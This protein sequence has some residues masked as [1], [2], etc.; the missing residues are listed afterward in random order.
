MN[1]IGK[2]RSCTETQQSIKSCRRT[3]W[4]R[5]VLWQTS[6]S[7][8]IYLFEVGFSQVLVATCA[9]L[10]RYQISECCI[11]INGLFPNIWTA[12]LLK[13]YLSPHRAALAQLPPDLVGDDHSLLFHCVIHSTTSTLQFIIYSRDSCY[14]L[15]CPF[16]R[17]AGMSNFMQH[18]ASLHPTALHW[19]Y[20]FISLD[21]ARPSPGSDDRRILTSSI[22]RQQRSGHDSMTISIYGSTLPN[23]K[24]HLS[25]CAGP[26]NKVWDKN[27]N[28]HQ[29]WKKCS[30]C[31]C[32]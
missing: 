6:S 31:L 14:L 21:R 10:P 4:V 3:L 2:Q 22:M 23:K 13:C 26:S 15:R 27:A 28:M 1:V 17:G 19:S 24:R 7:E 29:S 9:L 11:I 18:L 5:L 8:N 32:L 16:C 12:C 20:F 25:R 30:L